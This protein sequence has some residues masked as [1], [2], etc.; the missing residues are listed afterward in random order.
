MD[1]KVKAH[2]D[3]DK[4]L[5]QAVRLCHCTLYKGLVDKDLITKIE[6]ALRANRDCLSKLG[7]K[8]KEK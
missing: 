4:Q 5:L 6:I 3:L 1:K 2:I 7:E 8:E